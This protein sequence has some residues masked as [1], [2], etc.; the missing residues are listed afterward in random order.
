MCIEISLSGVFNGLGRTV[1]PSVVSMVFTGLRI[2]MA[3]L[4]PAG[5]ALGLNGVWWSISVS[6]IFKGTILL[7]WFLIV[8]FRNP[9]FEKKV[10]LKP[11][12]VEA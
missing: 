1:P 6:S 7:G 9:T 5:L 12:K 4:F 2:P 8:L 10:K 11:K 3:I